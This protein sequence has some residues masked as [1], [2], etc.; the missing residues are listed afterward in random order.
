M[1]ERRTQAERRAATRAALVAAGRELFA[2]RG[3]RRRQQRGDRR[4]GRGHPRGAVPPLRR[5]A[6]ACSPPSTRRSRRRSS[7]GLDF[8]GLDGERP[9]RRAHLRR[10]ISSCSTQPRARGSRRIALLDAPTVLGWEEWHEIEARYGLGL[11]EA[12]LS[13]AIAAGQIEALP[14][15]E[16]ALILLGALVEA[17]LQLARADDQDGARKRTGEALRA[18]LEGLRV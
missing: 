2:E 9:A 17:A 5:Q 1:A 13:A 7:R 11:I 6:R 8:S 10:P 18:L 12:G 15:P 4:R 3:L 16:L 14:V